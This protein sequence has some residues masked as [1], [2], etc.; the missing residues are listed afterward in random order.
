MVRTSVPVLFAALV[1]GGC[2][3]TV[4]DKPG[5]NKPVPPPAARPVGPPAAPPRPAQPANVMKPAFGQPTPATTVQPVQAR[6]VA[7]AVTPKPATPAPA[8]VVAPAVTSPTIF[9][10]GTGGAFKGLAFAIAPDSKRIPDLNTLTPFGTVYTDSF[11]VKPQPFTG[12]FPGALM[13]ED[14][15]AIRY[16]GLFNVPSD[17]PY[18]F[19]IMAD[20]GAQLFIDGALVVDAQVGGPGSRIPTG[21]I[22]TGTR[23]LKAGPHKLRLDYMQ[24]EKGTV[25]LEVFMDPA[26]SGMQAATPLVGTTPAGAANAA[27]GAVP[28]PQTT[29]RGIPAP[30][31]E[32]PKPGTK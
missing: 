3:V 21:W 4:Y 13:Q 25:S 10:N 15:F 7:T 12:G 9:G 16:E 5:T 8:G 27:G 2:T 1:L 32:R 6:P 14:W 26:K 11:Q 29:G 30:P 17:G 24:A 22:A 31:G 23:E 20:D 19:K 28:G 18:M